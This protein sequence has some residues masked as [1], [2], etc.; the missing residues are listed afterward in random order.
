MEFATYQTVVYQS[1]P[2]KRLPGVLDFCNLQAAGEGANGTDR[3][4]WVALVSVH[5]TD[6]YLRIYT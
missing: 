2:Q 6:V 5:D 3:L 1:T 4:Y